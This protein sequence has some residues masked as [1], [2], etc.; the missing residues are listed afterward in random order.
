MADNNNISQ[1]LNELGSSLLNAGN[2]SVYTVPAG[3]FEGL[4][5]Q[6]LRR[7]RA[8]EAHS[9]A[10]ELAHLSPLLSGI[11]KAMP[12]HIPAGYF[13]S[14][15]D[16][17]V[18]AMMPADQSADEELE[19]LSPLLAG[20]NKEMPFEVPQGYFDTIS[21]PADQ[22]APAKV[23]K[24]S[25][26]RWFRMAAAAVIVGIVATSAFFIFKK[27][28]AS[29]G[30]VIARFEKDVKKMNEKEKESVADFL[31]TDQDDQDGSMAKLGPEKEKEINELLK[32]LSDKELSEFQQQND[33]IS[34]ILLTAS[35]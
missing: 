8:M 32:D 21:I 10:E 22:Q 25:S 34:D 16:R 24:M 11:D 20:L 5:E 3:Y 13:D 28:V 31:D 35:E 17:M 33:D 30:Q 2:Q 14:I 4:A 15:E 27:P 18:Y 29:E 6:M 19:T 9:A 26:R 12:Y 23:V 7:I 1:E